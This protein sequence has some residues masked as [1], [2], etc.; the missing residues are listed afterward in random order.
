MRRRKYQLVYTKYLRRAC[1]SHIELMITQ[2]L[3][4]EIEIEHLNT[5]LALTRKVE[6]E[7]SSSVHINDGVVLSMVI[8]QRK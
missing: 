8:V 1:D 3:L 4:D 2:Q 5:E 6:D 7:R